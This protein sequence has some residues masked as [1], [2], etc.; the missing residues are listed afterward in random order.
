MS[1]LPFS[2][3]SEPAISAPV[4]PE[5][6]MRRLMF[7]SLLLFSMSAPAFATANFSCSAADEKIVTRAAWHPYPDFEFTACIRAAMV[8]GHLAWAD[9]KARRGRYGREI[10]ET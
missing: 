5:R 8:N 7:A 6:F 9:G 4:F 10:Y 1:A 2:A 3:A